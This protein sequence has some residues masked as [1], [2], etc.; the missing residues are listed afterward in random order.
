MPLAPDI[1]T[2]TQ[3]EKV[4]A[5][6]IWLSQGMLQFQA[7]CPTRPGAAERLALSIL[8]MIRDEVQLGWRLSREEAWQRAETHLQR[9]AAMIHSGVAHDA[10]WHLTLAMRQVTAV[11]EAAHKRLAKLRPAESAG[12]SG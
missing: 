3:S 12:A 11:G 2:Y 6:L 10:P 4:K 7:D 8:G 5:G 9:A 1:L